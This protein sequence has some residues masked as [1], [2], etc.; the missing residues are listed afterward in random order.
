VLGDIDFM[1]TGFRSGLNFLALQYL[2]QIPSQ[3]VRHAL[4][5][6]MG[7]KLASSS[8]IYMGGKIRDPHNIQ[9]GECTTIGHR[10]TLD[11]RGGLR[12]GDNVNLSSEV[13]IWTAEH[14]LHDPDFG[15]TSGEV[16]IDDYAWISCRSVVLPGV[17]I[18]KGAVVAAGAIV[19]KSVEPYTVV[20]GVPAKPIGKRPEN[21]RYRLGKTNSIWL[22]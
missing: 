2:T 9:I 16:V 12:I 10:C 4:L 13:M 19:T 11:G 18:G 6:R 22:V 15:A 3:N 21:L 20:G 7:M 14:D 17:H 8:L 5:R 1:L